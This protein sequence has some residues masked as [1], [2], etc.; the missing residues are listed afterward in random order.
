MILIVA[1]LLG[2][3]FLL[4]LVR[5]QSGG[6]ID[7]L[8][9][10]PLACMWS[11]VSVVPY[12]VYT[13]FDR[14]IFD[15]RVLQAMDGRTLEEGVFWFGMVQVLAFLALIAG[16]R[17]TLGTSIASLIPPAM[18]RLDKSR[19]NAAAIVA[20]VVALGSYLAFLV[21]VGGLGFV[22]DNLHRRTFV[23]AGNNYFLAALALLP[24]A[25]ALLIY[26]NR[27]GRSALRSFA[28]VTM[29]AASVAILVTL[30]GRKPAMTLFVF[31]LFV[32]HYG[33]E[34]IR[35][36]SFRHV[37]VAL[38]LGLFFIL[39]PVLRSEGG[40]SRVAQ[41][42]GVLVLEASENV[43]ALARDVSYVYT[44]VYVTSEFAPDNIWLGASYRDLI[45]APV[46]S[47]L[48]DGKP[49]V[50]D[51]VYI[52]SM[53]EGR[54]V[55]PGMAFADL[56][57]SSFP[58]E[59]LATVYMNFWL[60]GVVVAMYLLGVVRRACYEYMVNTNYGLLQILIYAHVVL[61]FHFSNLRIVQLLTFFATVFLFFR[62][63]FG[64]ISRTRPSEQST[65][66]ATAVSVP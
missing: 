34:R 59:T 29:V 5:V 2:V 43:G 22:L 28:I 16:S 65:R 11:F 51:G 62:V 8:A 21:R 47:G 20:V 36:P 33:V 17:S 48:I 32:K 54:T 27:Y 52:R 31:A 46:P 1:L 4:P 10:V 26:G 42:P 37:V 45:Y 18:V 9:P 41:D 7:L 44:Y 60:P 3:L 66:G 49:P 23:Q 64:G 12:L 30:G 35:R 39:N 13:H 19:L 57:Q 58:G 53:I 50:D 40:L 6:R 63:F 55:E 56:Y 15:A 25:V 61:F 14:S 38:V 24:V